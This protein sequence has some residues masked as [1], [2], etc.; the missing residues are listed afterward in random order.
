MCSYL[1]IPFDLSQVLFIATANT[2]S[3]IPSA[4]LDRMEVCLDCL[5]ASLPHAPP[6]PQVIEVPGYTVEEKVEIGKRH[7]LPKLLEQ[8]GLDQ[9][10]LQLPPAS[11]SLIGKGRGNREVTV[12][13]GTQVTAPVAVTDYTAEAGVRNFERMLGTVCRAAAVK[14]SHNI[15][16]ACMPMRVAMPLRWPVMIKSCYLSLLHQRA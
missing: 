3:K 10:Q 16:C 4:L 9:D 11:L 1:N 7:L 6:L 5:S 15:P 8:H 13:T 14:V 2:A 12:A